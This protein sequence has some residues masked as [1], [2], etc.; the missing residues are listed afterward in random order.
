MHTDAAEKRN[1]SAVKNL[2]VNNSRDVLLTIIMLVIAALMC[3]ALRQFDEGDTYV[4]LLF[5][6]AVAVISRWT[7]G[8]FW[9]IFS[10]FFG[11]VCVNYVFTYPYWRINFT[12][13]GYPITF[14][15]LLGVSLIIS[16]MTT[17]IKRQE[18]LRLEADREAIRANL[19]RA[20]SHDIRTPLTSIIGNTS[21][22]LDDQGLLSSE[23]KRSLLLDISEDSQWLVRMVE[24]ILSITRI[25]G[26]SHTIVTE[27]ETPE[28]VIG[29]S[30][31]KFTKQFPNIAISVQIP[32]VVLLIP[33]DITLIQQVLMNL[34][35]NA[36]THGK[37]SVITLA[38]EKSEN[39]ARF[40]VRD[41]GTGIPPDALHTI[42]E[43]KLSGDPQ[44]VD[45]KKN[46]GIGLSV[47]HTIIQAHE[48]SM[49][50]RNLP[51]GGAEFTFTLPIAEEIED[52]D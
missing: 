46:M 8:F 12:M 10:S 13:T 39:G 6:L 28:D 14:V 9:G 41:N 4:G 42:F 18:R 2:V 16:T 19:L 32:D 25:R 20:M 23:Q 38:V 50:A 27:Y 26:G 49:E 1:L 47:C 52:E 31:R 17:Q 3:F 51:N 11:V 30:V 7:D 37:A 29:E 35:D 36:V 45:G 43:P 5:V 21:V 24:N 22:L 40:A 44:G 34:M 33:M 15:T 48:G